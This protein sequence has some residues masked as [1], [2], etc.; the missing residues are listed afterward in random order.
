MFSGSLATLRCTKS[1]RPYEISAPGDSKV[2][3]RG[4]Q[5]GSCHSSKRYVYASGADR[6]TGGFFS[7]ATRVEARRA[8]PIAPQGDHRATVAA[9][10]NAPALLATRS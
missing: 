1:R 3:L 6:G 7:V 4:S 8:V 9:A 10:K 5:H 2:P